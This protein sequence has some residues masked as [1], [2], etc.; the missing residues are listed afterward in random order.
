MNSFERKKKP[1]RSKSLSP[2]EAFHKNA[3]SSPPPVTTIV[4]EAFVKSATGL[5]AIE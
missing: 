4:E 2:V 1:V 5:I 3:L